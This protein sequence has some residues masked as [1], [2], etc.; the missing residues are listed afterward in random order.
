V[1]SVRCVLLLGACTLACDA[2]TRQAVGN[3]SSIIVIAEDS[4]WRAAGD[5][6]LRA[7]EPRIFTVR[8]ERTF[9]VSQFSPDDVIWRD[10]RIFRNVLVIGGADAPWVRPVLERAANASRDGVVQT[11]NVWARNQR[12]TALVAADGATVLRHATQLARAI[13]SVFRA[14]VVQ[15]M[16]VSTADTMLRDTLRRAHGFTLLLPKVYSMV[17]RDSAVVLYQNNTR[18]GGDLI[19]SVLVT[20]RA[21]LQPA[22]AGAAHA[23]RDSVAR[24]VYRPA[25]TTADTIARTGVVLVNGGRGVEVQGVWSGSDASWPSSGPY[26]TRMIPCAA[27]ARTYLLDAWVFAPGPDR[28]KYEYLIQLNTLLNT[29]AC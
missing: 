9:D 15:R 19:R 7:L 27:Q 10:R 2:P 29:F 8:S 1:S 3:T 14:D 5:S 20:W 4:L 24:T 16:Y 6:L 28:S 21:G 13:D 26:L 11:T 17:Q 23:W 22:S 25:Q 18:I 12:V